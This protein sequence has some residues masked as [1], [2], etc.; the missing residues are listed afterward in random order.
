MLD[1][2]TVLYRPVQKQ[3]LN[4]KN[5]IEKHNIHPNNFAL[6]R[7]MAGDKSDN[8]EGVGNIGLATAYKRF[9]FLSGSDPVTLTE[10][11]KYSEEQ[12]KNR[13]LKDIVYIQGLGQCRVVTKNRVNQDGINEP[14]DIYEPIEEVEK[15]K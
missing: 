1:D 13:K 12:L 8:L 10:I 5:L 2:K 7:A 6:A 11:L 9:P 15:Y 14:Y 4:K 3:V